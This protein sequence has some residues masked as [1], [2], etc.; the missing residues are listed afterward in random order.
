MG[1]KD[2][3]MSAHPQPVVEFVSEVDE[4]SCVGLVV[5]RV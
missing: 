1:R 4:S 5:S 3:H 2:M